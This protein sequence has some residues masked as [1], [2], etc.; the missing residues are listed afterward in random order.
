MSV[1]FKNEGE[2]IGVGVKTK[3]KRMSQYHNVLVSLQFQFKSC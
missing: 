1:W 3:K 2:E